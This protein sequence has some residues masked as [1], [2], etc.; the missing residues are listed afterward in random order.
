MTAL[1]ETCRIL[2][3]R[4]PLKSLHE[5]RLGT[6]CRALN[7]P[8]PG[9]LEEPAGVLDGIVRFEVSAG[10][11]D[12]SLRPPIPHFRNPGI[13][14]SRNASPPFK[15]ILS[16]VAH[17]PYPHKTTDRVQFDDALA[18]AQRRDA[19]DGLMVTLDGHVAECAIWSVFWW[20][21]E[22]LMCP[23]L[24]VGILPGVARARL[25]Q[26]VPLEERRVGPVALA[27]RPM[28]VANAA[29]GVVAVVSLNGRDVP[30]DRRTA[31]LAGQFWG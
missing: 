29:R 20:E 2:D 10:G 5:A 9:S 27:G 8:F 25:S 22:R 21:G 18:R 6:S 14:E 23:S 1:I 28:F 4:L 16:D 12:V 13:S 24:E 3:G 30:G 7:I 19:G 15:L 17:R 26:L 11:V 31:E